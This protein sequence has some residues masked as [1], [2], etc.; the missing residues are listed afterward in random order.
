MSLFLGWPSWVITPI[1]PV[2]LPMQTSTT[3]PDPQLQALSRRPPAS[4]LWTHTLSLQRLALSLRPSASDSTFRLLCWPFVQYSALGGLGTCT[5][6]MSRRS[7][8]RT[9]NTLRQTKKNCLAECQHQIC[10]SFLSRLRSASECVSCSTWLD[11]GAL[12]VVVVVDSV[13]K[14]MS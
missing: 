1:T 12:V 4:S 2:A 5:M 13:V 7:I 11:N 10:F 8:G 3:A 9:C 6:L 14:A